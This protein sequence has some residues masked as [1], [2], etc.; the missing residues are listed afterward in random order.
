MVGNTKIMNKKTKK[1]SFIFALLAPFIFMSCENNLEHNIAPDKIYVVNNELTRVIVGDVDSYNYE[2]NVVKSGF[3]K[4][5]SKV[6]LTINSSALAEYNVAKRTTYKVLPED[7][8]I[9]LKEQIEISKD[10]YQTSFPIYFIVDRIKKLQG[11]KNIKYVLPCAIDVVEDGLKPS[12]AKQLVTFIGI[13]INPEHEDVIQTVV[14]DF[15]TMKDWAHNNVS[16]SPDLIILED[17]K[18]RITTEAET[19]Q[20]KKAFTESWDFAQGKY[21]W[22]VYVSNLGNGE[23]C[24]IGAFLYNDDHHELDFEIAS[25]KTAAREEYGAQDNE[26]LVYMTSQDNPWFQKVTKVKKNEWYTFEI[27]LKLKDGLYHA[28]WRIDGE[29]KAEQKMQFGKETK[30]RVFCSLENLHPFGD[31]L[32]LKDNY[33]LFDNVKYT[34]YK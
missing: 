19:E 15:N 5:G 27:D 3:N 9:L 24:S 33:T 34:E 28:T 20:R 30:F 4:S 12:N 17:G 2:L 8:Y 16:D 21:Q 32:P 18:L 29:T 14:W 26:V 23:K 10:E 11:I 22:R 25:G 13:E 1:T 31:F 6:N 7:C